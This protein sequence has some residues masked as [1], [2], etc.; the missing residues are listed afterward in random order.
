[1]LDLWFLQDY[2]HLIKTA[3]LQS[4]IVDINQIFKDLGVLVFDQG[5]LVG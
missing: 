2:T 3:L 1:M 4:D 5:L